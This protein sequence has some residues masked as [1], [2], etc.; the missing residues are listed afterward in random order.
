MKLKQKNSCQEV[1]KTSLKTR[2]KGSIN[3]TE[4]QIALKKVK[5]ERKE[6]DMTHGVDIFDLKKDDSVLSIWDFAGFYFY[7][8][9]TLFYFYLFKLLFLFNLI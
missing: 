4:N 7:F 3:Q 8:Y 5:N 1:G 6:E 2:F 9:F